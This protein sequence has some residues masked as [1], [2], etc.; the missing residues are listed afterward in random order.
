MA[1]NWPQPFPAGLA[2]KFEWEMLIIPPLGDCGSRFQILEF[3]KIDCI[4]ST[5]IY[6]KPTLFGGRP[7]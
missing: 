4:R 7:V 2:F 3:T 1:E 6:K 5:E